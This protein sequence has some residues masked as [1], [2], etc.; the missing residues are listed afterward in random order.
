MRGGEGG[1]GGAGGGETFTYS[2]S[3]D[4]VNMELWD[5]PYDEDKRRKKLPEFGLTLKK[6]SGALPSLSHFLTFFIL[7]HEFA[8]ISSTHRHITHTHT[9]SSHARAHTRTRTLAHS[10][11]YAHTKA[12]YLLLSVGGEVSSFVLLPR[13]QDEDDVDERYGPRDL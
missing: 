10:H 2:Y 7:P 4:F 13:P 3:V 8:R 6:A 11:T 12:A 1:G 5:V 9:H